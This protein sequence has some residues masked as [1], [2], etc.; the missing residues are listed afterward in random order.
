VS[1]DERFVSGVAPDGVWQ[2]SFEEAA[3]G[4]KLA[5]VFK[6]GWKEPKEQ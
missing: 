4:A 6:V 5:V 3:K 1:C 2:K